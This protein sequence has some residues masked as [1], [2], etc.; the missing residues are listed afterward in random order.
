[1]DVSHAIDLAVF[2]DTY[3]INQLKNQSSDMIMECLSSGK[4]KPTPEAISLVYGNM[5]DGS[6]LQDLFSLAF[7]ILHTRQS[8][9]HAPPLSDYMQWKDVFER[10]ANFG[11]D[12]FRHSQGSLSKLDYRGSCTYHDHTDVP[13]WGTQNPARRSRC[14]D[15]NGKTFQLSEPW[16]EDGSSDMKLVEDGTDTLF[17]RTRDGKRSKKSS[18]SISSTQEHQEPRLMAGELIVGQE[19]ADVESRENLSLLGSDA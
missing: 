17:R 8:A 3:Q 16:V 14:P 2:A 18:K 9:S 1:M 15:S 10:F 12:F 5:P 4:Y 7:T 13:G 19:T 6:K 11:R